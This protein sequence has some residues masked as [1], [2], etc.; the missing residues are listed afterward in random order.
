M[1]RIL[2]EPEELQ[3]DGT[4]TLDDDRAAHIR[5]VLHAQAGQTVRTGWIN[6]RMGTSR[7]LEV[8]EHHMR[9]LPDHTQETPL[10][11]F[12]LLLAMPRPKVLKRLWPQ[13]AALGVGRVV[14]LNA[15]KVEKFYFSSQWVDLA[16]YRPLLVEGLTQAGLTRLPEVLVRARF[17]PFVEDELDALFPQTHRLLAHPG[18][19]GLRPQAAGGEA[20]PLLAVGPEGGWTDYELKMLAARGFQLF[21]LGERTLRT[22]TACIALISV[23]EWWKSGCEASQRV[24]EW[25]PGGGVKAPKDSSTVP[26]YR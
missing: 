26:C 25:S 19:R 12:D 5:Q 17:K 22:D 6:G 1:N 13:L 3:T 23:L 20:R 18:P 16:Y 10:P 11:W 15:N 2:L 24:P 4:V 21:S 14:L 7:L 8:S 9:L